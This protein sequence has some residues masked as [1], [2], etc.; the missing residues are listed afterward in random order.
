MRRLVATLR[1]LGGRASGAG[2]ARDDGVV[3]ACRAL[4]ELLT[5]APDRRCAFL[6]DDGAAALAELLEERSPKVRGPGLKGLD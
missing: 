1:P 3:D 4:A 6:T 5:G 2:S